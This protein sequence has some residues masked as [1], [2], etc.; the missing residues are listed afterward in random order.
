MY[1]AYFD[2]IQLQLY[3]PIS[4]ISLPIIISTFKIAFWVQL[5]MIIYRWCGATQWSMVNLPGTTPLK[6]MNAPS[7]IIHHLPA[8][9]QLGA[10]DFCVSLH[11]CCI[12]DRLDLMQVLSRQSQPPWAHASNSPVMP[13]FTWNTH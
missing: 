7:F 3:P 9:R 1:T 12:V 13:H 4:S 5:V 11:S 10:Q 8:N 2:H 6:K